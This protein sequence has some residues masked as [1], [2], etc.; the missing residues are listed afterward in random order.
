MKRLESQKGQV[1]L[2]VVLT[3]I[4][5]LTVGLSVVS[6][7][8]T[9][10][11]IS[12][13][14]E[15]SQRAFQ[16]AEA[17]IENVLKSSVSNGVAQNSLSNNSTYSTSV[18]SINGKNFLLNG[19]GIVDQD[20]GVDVWLSDYPNY[21]N[22]L[23]A[24]PKSP[25]TVNLFWGTTSQTNKCTNTFG[26]STTPALEVLIVYGDKANPS[27]EKHFFDPCSPSS[28]SS[29]GESVS[30]ISSNIE[31]VTLQYSNQVSFSIT[32]GLIMKVIPIFNSTQVGII[33]SDFLP[34]QGKVVN[35]TGKSGDTVR[36]VSYFSSYPQIP[37]EIFP[38][39]IVSQ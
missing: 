15:E 7:S 31:G 13:Q 28:R 36:K 12:K 3:M 20:T 29:G 19:G 37:L 4:L 34:N 24:P 6:R 5:A 1:L 38:Y 35:S 27:L 25:V 2:I 30:T 17:G 9:N 16:A 26:S 11:K 32:R 23:G 10:V 8:I 39:A 21:D 33:A 14:N 18:S 22:A